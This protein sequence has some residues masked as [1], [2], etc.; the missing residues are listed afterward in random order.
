ML[1]FLI[2]GIGFDYSMTEIARGSGVGWSSFTNI[3]QKLLER[4]IIVSTRNIENAKL[5]TLNKKDEFVKRI[6][7]LDWEL[8][9][10]EMERAHKEKDF[11]SKVV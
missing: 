2:S 5:F 3:W 9:K 1:D 8:T 6:V 7:N 11:V 4:K 10:L